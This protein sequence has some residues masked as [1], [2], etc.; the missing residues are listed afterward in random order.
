MEVA[1]LIVETRMGR[2]V[3]R[4]AR[5]LIASSCACAASAV[6]VTRTGVEKTVAS[7]SSVML[8]TLSMANVLM[9]I[10]FVILV[11]KERNVIKE[12]HV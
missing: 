12:L 4:I 5:I 6:C 7:L 11:T 9:E 3:S 1:F 8:A 2:S 10:V